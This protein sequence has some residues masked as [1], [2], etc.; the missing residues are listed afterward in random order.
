VNCAVPDVVVDGVVTVPTEDRVTGTVDA[1]D[2]GAVVEA[3]VEGA[4]VVGALTEELA[5]EGVA[6]GVSEARVPVRL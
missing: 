5:A 3:M 2:V 4:V 6:V 1:L